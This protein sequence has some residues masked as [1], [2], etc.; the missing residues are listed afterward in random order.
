V[1]LDGVIALFLL[2]VCALYNP[3]LFISLAGECVCV[4]CNLLYSYNKTVYAGIY[5]FIRPGDRIQRGVAAHAKR[6]R[7]MKY[8][9]RCSNSSALSRRYS[10]SLAYAE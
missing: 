5:L 2:H 6:A 10:F 8:K 9:C 3:S 7:E 1:N 4:R